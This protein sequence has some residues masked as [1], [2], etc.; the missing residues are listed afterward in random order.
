MLKIRVYK[1]VSVYLEFAPYSY[2]CRLWKE[3]W[4]CYEIT[5]SFKTKRKAIRAAKKKIRQLLRIML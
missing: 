5:G 3:S 1:G 2:R 4:P